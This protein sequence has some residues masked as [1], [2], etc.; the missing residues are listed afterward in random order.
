MVDDCCY[1]H[2]NYFLLASLQS[3]GE[4]FP[5]QGAELTYKPG[6]KA[7][8]FA[9]AS[10]V[11]FVVSWLPEKRG[12]SGVFAPWLNRIAL[13][14]TFFLTGWYWLRSAV[15]VEKD[16]WVHLSFPLFGTLL[17][18]GLIIFGLVALFL[19]SFPVLVFAVDVIRRFRN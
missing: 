17:F 6:V 2:Y 3:P 7:A 1:S 9:L 5:F 16:A 19:I 15:E 18:C 4:S 12:F 14:G 13:A 11:L 10:G 8:L